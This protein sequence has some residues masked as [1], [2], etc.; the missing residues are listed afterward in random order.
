MLP[1]TRTCV[2]FFCLAEKHFCF[3]FK[4]S[5]ALVQNSFCFFVTF[6]FTACRHLEIWRR[7]IGK[8]RLPSY[9][10][11]R[12][13]TWQR[14]QSDTS[15]TWFALLLEFLENFW[16]FVISFRGPEKLQEKHIFPVLREFDSLNFVENN[17]V[18]Q[19]TTCRLLKLLII[20]NSF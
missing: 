3:Q 20:C 13:E 4:I 7:L 5:V 18:L 15:G 1:C 8:T 2:L 14:N 6:E 17:S 10:S 12:E 16:N 11:N 19:E 9:N